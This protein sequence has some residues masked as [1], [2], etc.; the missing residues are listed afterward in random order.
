MAAAGGGGG[1]RIEERSL[2]EAKRRER[3]AKGVCE[4][5]EWKPSVEDR[6]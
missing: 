3:E 1:S 4:V 6:I 2:I 5:Q